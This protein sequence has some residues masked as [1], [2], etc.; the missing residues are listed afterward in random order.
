MNPRDSGDSVMWLLTKSLQ[1]CFAQ[2]CASWFMHITTDP[3]L[4]HGLLQ[5]MMMQSGTLTLRRLQKSR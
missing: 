1:S 2:L 3:A 4:A 5:S